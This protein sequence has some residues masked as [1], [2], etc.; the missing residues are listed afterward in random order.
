MTND[1]PR[2]LVEVTDVRRSFG[3]VVAL[4][5]VSLTIRENEFF[6]LL[7]PSGCGKTTLL[8]ILAGLDVPDE[9]TL[10]LD[11]DDL[12]AMP[13]HRRPINLM[14]QSYA[15]FP[16]LNVEKNVSYGLQRERRPKDE[17]RERV[18][19]ALEIVGL[20]GF[21][22]RRPH[23]L[24]GGQRQR[25]ALA[26]AMVKRPRL[27]LLDEPLAALDKKIRTHMQ[28]ELKRLQHEAGI[29]FVVVTHD[30]EEAMS[31]AD[32]VAVMNEGQVEQLAPPVELY[33]RP[34][35]YF[36]ADFIGS[37]NFFSGVV[38]SGGS[39]VWCGGGGGFVV[40]ADV[41]DVE[42]GQEV[43]VSV[44]PER[45]VIGAPPEG[46]DHLSGKVADVQ[47][48]GGVSHCLVEVADRDVPLLVA[49]QGSTDLQPGARVDVWWRSSDA[50]VLPR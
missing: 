26:R 33:E 19:E 16:H 18:K 36:V 12:V 34:A 30:Q 37:S 28:M 13:P 29:T 38:E 20:S 42:D 14:F 17:V 25:V 2:P 9:G 8:R 39:R 15:L 46:A 23:E 50:W 41:S 40:H 11:G 47:F 35:S 44:R 32:R 49:L 22:R 1:D 6:A 21:E 31:M 45:M 5:G 4:D 27:L 3:D 43:R 24:S 10:T 48:Y 7:G